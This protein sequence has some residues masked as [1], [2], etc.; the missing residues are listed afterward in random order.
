MQ[1]KF[2]SAEHALNLLAEV[3]NVD[4][5][6]AVE[7][8]EEIADPSTSTERKQACKEYVLSIL[9]QDLREVYG[10][11]VAEYI[12]PWEEWEALAEYAWPAEDF[13]PQP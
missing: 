6:L 13:F 2:E 4:Y 11:D 5:D 3:D 10:E 8:L 12:P 9:M 7:T 1:N